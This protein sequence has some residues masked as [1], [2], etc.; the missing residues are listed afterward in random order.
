MKSRTLSVSKSGFKIPAY[1]KIKSILRSRSKTFL[2]NLI[3]AMFSNL[4]KTLKI[5]FLIK[6]DRKSIGRKIRHRVS[7]RRKSRVRRSKGRK[8]RKRR[9]AKQRA[10]DKRLGQMAKRRHR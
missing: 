4:T 3:M 1:K 8:S 6:I 5:K 9:S 2:V 10:N 7:K